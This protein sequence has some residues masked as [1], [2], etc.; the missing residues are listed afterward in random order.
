MVR[1]TTFFWTTVVMSFTINFD[2]GVWLFTVDEVGTVDI[3]VIGTFTSTDFTFV[4]VS[5]IATGDWDTLEFVTSASTFLALW[6]GVGVAHIMTDAIDFDASIFCVRIVVGITNVTTGSITMLIGSAFKD[7]ACVLDALAFTLGTVLGIDFTGLGFILTHLMTLALNWVAH[8]VIVGTNFIIG[9]VI[10]VSTLNF[11]TCPFFT[12]ISSR[13]ITSGQAVIVMSTFDWFTC[14]FFTDVFGIL[15]SKEIACGVAF[16]PTVFVFAAF[17]FFANIVE[18]SVSWTEV[19]FAIIVGST[20]NI[21]TFVT[22]FKTG[23]DLF[24]AT[25]FS[26]ETIDFDT[27]VITAS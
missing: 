9:A 14:I 13:T 20:F 18:T 17:L 5:V 15:V 11:D 12:E 3:W 19:S 24:V 10:I 8:L 27:L 7:F 4:T 26:V 25:V 2:T 21:D 22:F 23:A 1:I 16:F 6:S